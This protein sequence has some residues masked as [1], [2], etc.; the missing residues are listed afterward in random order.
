MKKFILFITL[1]LACFSFTSCDWFDIPANAKKIGTGHIKSDKGTLFVEIDSVKYTPTSV[2]TGNITRGVRS[3]I[4]PVIG[5]QV[6][7]FYV[8]EEDYPNFIAGDKTEEDL[9]GHFSEN[10]TFRIIFG[11]LILAGAIICCTIDPL[12]KNTKQTK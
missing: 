3:T 1:I 5:M 2:Y 4:E 7:V 11:A 12:K 9:E 6:T 8:Y 10:R